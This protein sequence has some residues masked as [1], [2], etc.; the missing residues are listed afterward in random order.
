MEQ[1]RKLVAQ[2]ELV[3]KTRDQKLQQSL[4]Y[5][6]K[7]T[8]DRRTPTHDLSTMSGGILP[9]NQHFIT[10]AI[11]RRKNWFLQ[12]AGMPAGVPAATAAPTVPATSA[13]QDEIMNHLA[14][15]TSDLATGTQGQ[16]TVE[17]AKKLVIAVSKGAITSE[18]AAQVKGQLSDLLTKLTA[19]ISADPGSKADLYLRG[20]YKS[21][22]K[23]YELVRSAAKVVG[24]QRGI[25]ATV[26][27]Q[28][29]D[30]A[31]AGLDGPIEVHDFSHAKAEKLAKHVARSI[32]GD[33]SSED[34]EDDDDDE[35]GDA[36]G[37][38]AKSSSKKSKS[39]ASSKASAKSAAKS[40]SKASEHDSHKTPERE[41][42]EVPEAPP[43]SPFKA[44]RMAMEGIPG[45]VGAREYG[46]EAFGLPW[47]YAALNTCSTM[48]E[49]K[50]IAVL[51]GKFGIPY[52]PRS[53]NV[54]Y[55]KQEIGRRL[56]LKL[57]DDDL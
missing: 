36:D 2:R 56:G 19:A 50:N 6:N 44:A 49:L 40:A 46:L 7:A 39:K 32:Y 3:K 38:T 20:I 13:H 45:P 34:D 8:A 15:I 23:A 51:M 14:S 1:L 52:A 47:S 21:L 24:N 28:H 31:K 54:E 25:K 53:R 16:N 26:K 17:E 41:E 33:R 22:E 43:E 9:Q 57:T 55:V 35:D 37:A 12:Q 42:H 29:A 27:A 4:A 10:Q 11:E 5:Q 18:E 48:E 30:L